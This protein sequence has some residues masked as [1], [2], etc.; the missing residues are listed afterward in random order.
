MGQN[1]AEATT[2]AQWALEAEPPA[3]QMWP[4]S[5]RAG[6]A[7]WTNRPCGPGIDVET[8]RVRMRS[9]FYGA[10]QMARWWRIRLPRQEIQELWV[11]SLAR[12]DPWSRKWQP[13]PIFLPS[14]S[15]GQRSLVGYSPWGS[16]FYKL[17]P[18]WMFQ[19]HKLHLSVNLDRT[20]FH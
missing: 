10:A 16:L 18:F 1:W 15:H 9:L 13:T 19:P 12:E 5:E 20:F 2:A 11:W 6:N 8:T 4:R 7:P 17:K 14:K 3:G